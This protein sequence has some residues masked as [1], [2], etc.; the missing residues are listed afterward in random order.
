MRLR[1][2]PE[3]NFKK[4][5]ILFVFFKFY[6]NTYE[7]DLAPGGPWQLR[8]AEASHSPGT[9]EHDLLSAFEVS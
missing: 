1:I 7:Q 8:P 6:K 2:D 9:S 4:K 5:V 3:N